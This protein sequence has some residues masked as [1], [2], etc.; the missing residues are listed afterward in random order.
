VNI[1][2]FENFLVISLFS[3]QILENS[4]TRSSYQERFL[5]SSS[6]NKNSPLCGLEKPMTYGSFWLGLI[7]TRRG[8]VTLILTGNRAVLLEE[9]LMQYCSLTTMF[10]GTGGVKQSKQPSFLIL[11]RNLKS[12]QLIQRQ[13]MMIQSTLTIH[14]QGIPL[15]SNA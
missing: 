5:C 11:R 10:C 4:V 9:K 13:Q 3:P 7:G 12:V 2:Q 15:V 6:K 1:R 8:L 14:N